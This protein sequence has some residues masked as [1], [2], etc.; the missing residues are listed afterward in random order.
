MYFWDKLDEDVKRGS[1]KNSV[2]SK[3]DIRYLDFTISNKCNLACIHCNPFVS[4]GWTKDGKK[5][6]KENPDYWKNAQI[7]YHGVEDMSFLDNLFA[8]PEYFR[9]LQWV[10]LRGGEPLYDES[11]K[12]IL[13]WFIDQGLASNIMLDISTNATVFDDDFQEIFKHFKH[14]ELLISIEAVDEL[15]SVV[16]G[17][18]FFRAVKRAIYWKVRGFV[19]RSCE[20]RRARGELRELSAL[21]FVAWNTGAC[22]VQKRDD[23]NG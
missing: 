17:G 12:A 2:D 4:T 16:R 1:I 21:F 9:N 5:L 18:S 10:A 19:G 6:N 8:D 11:C 3:P 22:A 15:Y 7:G 14:I 23:Q 13:Q 20:K